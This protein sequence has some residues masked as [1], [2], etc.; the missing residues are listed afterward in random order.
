MAQTMPAPPMLAVS[1]A[2]L[3]G[4]MSTDPPM[5][6]GIEDAGGFMLMFSLR[7]LQ[8]FVQAIGITQSSVRACLC[9]RSLQQGG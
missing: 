4:Y 9:F 3:S 6:K 1:N 5:A 2:N 7:C 8:A